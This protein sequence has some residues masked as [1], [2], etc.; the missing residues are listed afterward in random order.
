M[1]CRKRTSMIKIETIISDELKDK[2]ASLETIKMLVR[3]A[4]AASGKEFTEEEATMIVKDLH[5]D[6]P[7][8]PLGE[9][10]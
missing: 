7:F 8:N 5:Y 10:I 9:A 1:N 2:N 4:I 6:L 3:V